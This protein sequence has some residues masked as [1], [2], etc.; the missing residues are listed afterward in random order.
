MSPAMWA[1]QV[2]SESEAARLHDKCS[3]P[4]RT[5]FGLLVPLVPFDGSLNDDMSTKGSRQTRLTPLEITSSMLWLM[6]PVDGDTGAV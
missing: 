3:R 4:L 6:M 2:P 1:G 5:P